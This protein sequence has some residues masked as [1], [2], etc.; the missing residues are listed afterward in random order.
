MRTSAHWLWYTFTATGT[1]NTLKWISSAKL[2]PLCCLNSC[3]GQLWPAGRFISQIYFM[4]SAHRVHRDCNPGLGAQGCHSIVW[5][6]TGL[7][8]FAAT[9]PSAA[10]SIQDTPRCQ[11]HCLLRAQ[12][13]YNLI[14]CF[15]SPLPFPTASS[16]QVVVALSNCDVAHHKHSPPH[17]WPEP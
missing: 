10:F 12:T 13:L 5:G 6:T 3:Y 16:A 15:F 8:S 4:T 9:V 1:S 14:L 11:T 2:E 17:L 7:K